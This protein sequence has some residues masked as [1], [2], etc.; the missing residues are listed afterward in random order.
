MTHRH[1]KPIKVPRNCF[2]KTTILGVVVFA[3]VIYAYRGGQVTIY[4]YY[5]MSSAMPKKLVKLCTK[6][7]AVRIKPADIIGFINSP[8]T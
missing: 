3:E 4:P 1:G 8:F 5:N 7:Y 2:C 6:H